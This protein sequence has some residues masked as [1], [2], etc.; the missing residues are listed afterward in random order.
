MQVDWEFTTSDAS[1]AQSNYFSLGVA[2]LGNG[3][4]VG[5]SSLDVAEWNTFGL[6]WQPDQLQWRINGQVVRTLTRNKAGDSYP[7]SPSR[8]QM[9][10]WAGGN[11]TSPE[12]VRSW[13]GGAIDWDT[14][15]YTSQG[16]YAMELASFSMSCAPNSISNLDSTGTGNNVTSWVYTGKNDTSGQPV[17]QLNRA[18]MTFIDKPSAG[19]Y[20]GLPGYTQQQ[21]ANTIKDN[22]MWDGSGD[23]GVQ[24]SDSGSGSGGI[25]AATAKK[26][27]IPIGAAVAGLIVLW[28]IVMTCVRRRRKAA[29]RAARDAAAASGVGGG[30]GGG[31]IAAASSVPPKSSSTEG[32]GKGGYISSGIGPNSGRGKYEAIGDDYYDP[33]AYAASNDYL[34]MGAEKRGAGV[35]SAAAGGMAGRRAGDR[36][37]FA[38]S[39]AYDRPAYGSSLGHYA[40]GSST[41]SPGESAYYTPK[42]SGAGG[43]AYPSSA[44]SH[45]KWAGSSSLSHGA[46]SDGHGRD[47][48]AMQP[49][50]GANGGYWTRTQ[51]YPQY[52]QQ[53]QRQPQQPQYQQYGFDARNAPYAQRQQPPQSRGHAAY[54]GYPTAAGGGHQYSSNAPM[55]TSAASNLRTGA[56]GGRAAAPAPP[57]VQYSQ[58]S[59]PTDMGGGGQDDGQIYGYATPRYR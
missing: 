32:G 24:D 3:D 13:A 15:E 23:T 53:Q 51:A 28:A 47:S 40:D 7:R 37:S 20:Y 59:Y 30:G 36:V 26:Y 12:G 41:M 22:N 31:G 56:T 17:V 35:A 4:N 5:P 2:K 11:A 48:Y 34:P 18:P 25:S 38:S 55:P 44:Q 50:S 43:A 14:P 49:P 10:V 58:P 9:S 54:S 33:A 57:R 19:G 1:N 42:A 52:Q 29:R 39:A 45:S 8:V 6:N 27:G 16:F 46:S 21:T